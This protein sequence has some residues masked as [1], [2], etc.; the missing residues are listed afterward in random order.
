MLANTVSQCRS[1]PLVTK[2]V[3]NAQ[4]KLSR[5]R[6]RMS[7]EALH[8][9]PSIGKAQR[10]IAKPAGSPWLPS[11]TSGMGVR[12]APTTGRLIAI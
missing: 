5:S 9:V 11:G 12:G 4:W 8:V 7:S 6:S 2:T 3:N 10:S 1:L